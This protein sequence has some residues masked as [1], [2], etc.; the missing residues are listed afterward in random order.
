M[1]NLARPVTMLLT[2]GVSHESKHAIAMDDAVVVSLFSSANPDSPHAHVPQVLGTTFESPGDALIHLYEAFE[3][4]KNNFDMKLPASF[5][6]TAI[7]IRNKLVRNRGMPHFRQLPQGALSVLKWY[8]V[9]VRGDWEFTHQVSTR[10]I[11][12]YALAIHPESCVRLQKIRMGR[13]QD[14]GF[15]LFARRPIA[16][17]STVWEAVGMCPVDG[18]SSHSELSC[19]KTA[20]GQNLPAGSERVMYGPLRMVNHRCRTFNAEVESI[21][22]VLLPLPSLTWF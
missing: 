3:A 1:E 2:K 14:W 13:T 11:S 9:R 21:D 20:E 12:A 18:S 5:S 8:V 4:D 17:G 15:G 16:K 22:F 19:I 7:A 6:D 10:C